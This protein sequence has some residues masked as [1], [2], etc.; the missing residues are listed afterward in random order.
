VTFVLEIT[1]SLLIVLTTKVVT[2][3]S[4]MYVYVNFA[5][6]LQITNFGKMET[7]ELI[8]HNLQFIKIHLSVKVISLQ[9]QALKLYNLMLWAVRN[10]GN[11]L[12]RNNTTAIN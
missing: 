5:F 6:M 3:F 7:L 9:K 4:D 12:C 1:W 11:N 8:Y 10:D 2:I